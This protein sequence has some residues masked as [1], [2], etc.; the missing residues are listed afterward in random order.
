MHFSFKHLLKI[1]L[2][3][4]SQTTSPQHHWLW[5]PDAIICY[6]KTHKQL[7]RVYS[8]LSSR[9]LPLTSHQEYKSVSAQLSYWKMSL[10]QAWNSLNPKFQA[11]QTSVIFFHS[12]NLKRAELRCELVNAF[13]WHL[14]SGQNGFLLLRNSDWAEKKN[15]DRFF[16]FC[17]GY[18]PKP[19]RWQGSSYQVHLKIEVR[20]KAVT[21]WNAPV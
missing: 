17:W 21:A 18:H 13:L 2:S 4:F 8:S 20:G 12:T 16:L 5:T 3:A 15:T 9:G 14:N 19:D 10:C 1:T 6:D 11:Q 7:W